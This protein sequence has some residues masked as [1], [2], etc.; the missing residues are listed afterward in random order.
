MGEALPLGRNRYRTVASL[1]PVESPQPT[2]LFVSYQGADQDFAARLAAAVEESD[3][4]G[5]RVFYAPWD[6]RPGANIVAE[7]DRA[8]QKARYVGV[9]LSPEYLKADWTAGESSAS[10]FADPSGRLGK[11]IPIMHRHCQPPPLLRFRRYIDFEALGFDIGVAQLVAVL[12]GKP[13]PRGRSETTNVQRNNRQGGG[14]EATRAH[15]DAVAPDAIADLLYPNI[16]PVSN[17]PKYVWS[18]PTRLRRG[19]DLFQYYGP[20]RQV[21][22]FILAEDRLITFADLSAE[23]HP[24]TGVVE[25][26]DANRETWSSWIQDQEKAKRLHWLLD[27]CL[28]QRTRALRLRYE[29]RGKRAI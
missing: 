17:T 4:G 6:I 8:L 26:Y 5:L 1:A 22:P 28:R 19:R 20:D 7:L 13:L 24:F 9:V 18:A 21:P 14:I 16:F 3:G 23:G 11:V 25:E 27:D 12:R 2:D 29:K 10:I 15:L